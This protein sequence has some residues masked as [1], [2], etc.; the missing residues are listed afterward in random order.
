[1]QQSFFL[2]VRPPGAPQCGARRK[3]RAF[4]R[5]QGSHPASRMG[6]GRTVE[7]HCYRLRVSCTLKKDCCVCSSPFLCIWRV[8]RA[9]RG[10]QLAFFASLGISRS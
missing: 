2:S 4:N 5:P 6:N 1:M 10:R 7:R 8:L 9:A 3:A